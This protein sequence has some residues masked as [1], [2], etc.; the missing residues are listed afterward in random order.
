MKKQLNKLAVLLIIAA[1]FTLSTCDNIIG[2][3]ERLNLKGPVVTIDYPSPRQPV[4][5]K[6]Y[7]SGTISDITGVDRVIIRAKYFLEENG[8]SRNADFPMQWR[9]TGRLWEVSTN[10]G[11]SWFPLDA[12]T[13]NNEDQTVITPKWDGNDKA[14]NWT[15]PIN[16]S[17][18]GSDIADGLYQFTVMAWNYAGNSDENSMRS[19]NVILYKD[20]PT[21]SIISPTP[22]YSRLEYFNEDSELYTLRTMH[23]TP[24]EWR[25]PIYNSKF[26]NGKFNLQWQIED[27]NDVWAIEIRFYEIQTDLSND[28][29]SPICTCDHGSVCT[30]ENYEDDYVFRMYINDVLN[31]PTVPNPVHILRPNG[32]IEVPNLTQIS[33]GTISGASYHVKNPVSGNTPLQVVVTCINAAGLEFEERI[34]G[35]FVYWPESEKPWITFPESLP[36]VFPVNPDNLLTVFPAD[37]NDMEAGVPAKAFAYNPIA[38]VEYSIFRVNGSGVKEGAAVMFSEVPGSGTHNLVQ[39]KTTGVVTTRNPSQTKS[40]S[41]TFRPPAEITSYVVEAKAFDIHNNVSAEYKGYFKTK[42]VSWPDIKAPHTPVSTTPL[43]KTPNVIN[44]TNGENWNFTIRGLASDSVNVNSVYMVWIN[45]R[46][47]NYAAMSQ[48]AYFRDAEYEGWTAAEHH[49]RNVANPPTVPVATPGPYID[50]AF[51]NT[52]GHE[53][54]V[55]KLNIVPNPAN[56]G[57]NEQRRREVQY[58]INLKLRDDLNIWP[59]APGW[60]FLKSQVFVFKVTGGPENK[61]SVIVW[62]PEGSNIAPTVQITGVRLRKFDAQTSTHLPWHSLNLNMADELDIFNFNDQLE[63][64]G[65]WSED[66]AAYLGK[67]NALRDAFNVRIGNAVIPKNISSPGS[68]T[69]NTTFVINPSNDMVGNGTWTVTATVGN[70]NNDTTHVLRTGHL[71]DTLMINAEIVNIGGHKSEDMQT[72][73]VKSD[74]LSFM[75]LG[76]DPGVLDR[77]YKAGDHIDF[78]L[79][80]NKS[81]QLLSGANPILNLNSGTGGNTATAVYRTTPAQTA[82]STRQYFRYTVGTTDSTENIADKL[83]NVMSLNAGGMLHGNSNYPFTFIHGSETVKLVAES[84]AAPGEYDGYRVNILPTATHS[85]AFN[86][87]K[88]IEIDTRA[89]TLLSFAISGRGGWHG[90]ND[91]L[92]ITADFSEPVSFGAVTPSLTLGIANGAAT[93]RTTDR[94]EQNRNSLIFYYKVKANDQATAASGVVITSF[95]GNVIDIAGNEYNKDTFNSLA[96]SNR[97]PRDN[98]GTAARV[99]AI[100]LL[101]PTLEVHTSNE[102]ITPAGT[103]GGNFSQWD[104]DLYA[105]SNAFLNSTVPMNK[106]HNYYSE[107]LFVFIKPNEGAVF[108]PTFDRIEYSVNYGKDW[109][110]V[111]RNTMIRKN[112]PGNYELTARQVDAAG[113]V[114]PWSRPVTLF[115]DKG[116]LL[117]RIT[118]DK[119][120]GTYTD[121]S[122][123]IIPITLTFRRPVRVVTA[124]A[125]RLN[126]RSRTNGAQNYIDLPIP[127]MPTAQDT[128]TVN[129]TVGAN[130]TTN[131]EIIQVMDIVGG[132]F[133]DAAGLVVTDMVNLDLVNATQRNFQNQKNIIIQTGR[134][135]RIGVPEFIPDANLN[136]DGTVPGTLQIEFSSRI[137]RGLGEITIVQSAIGYRLPGVISEAQFNLYRGITNFTNFYRKGT[138]GYINGVGPDT[139]TK[140]ILD[141]NVNT[142]TTTHS[143]A[144]LN[145]QLTGIA[146][147]LR[148]AEGM[149]IAINSSFVSIND[150][151]LSIRLTGTNSLKVQGASYEIVYPERFIQD[152]LGNAC[153]A[154][155]GTI[156]TTGVARPTIR[157]SKPRETISL[158]GTPST[159]QPRIYL[160]DLERE[161]ISRVQIRMDC[162]T[163]G[164]TVRYTEAEQSN[165]VNNSAN[166]NANWSWVKNQTVTNPLKLSDPTRPTAPTSGSTLFNNAVDNGMITRGPGAVSGTN[167]DIYNGYK[168]RIYAVGVNGTTVGDANSMA[169]EVLF[170][171]VLTFKGSA[172]TATGGQNFLTS[173]VGNQLWVRGSNEMTGTTIAGFPLTPDDNFAQL[174]AN[175]ERAGIRLMTRINTNDV[176]LNNSTWQYVTW[177]INAT[178]FITLYLGNDIGSSAAMLQQYGPQN[179][180]SQTENW[181]LLKEF[182]VMYPGE[183]RWLNNLSPQYNDSG[184]SRVGPFTFVGAFTQRPTNLTPNLP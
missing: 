49:W 88:T 19:R 116:D 129:Y 181:S 37:P 23:E 2:L 62:S 85:N 121:D 158:H 33:S 11:N 131:G 81:V 22:L 26:Y 122:D 109:A 147:D 127:V 172:V 87:I 21:V 40:F 182:Y 138:N 154:Y 133:H 115:W 13:L 39:D 34:A 78:F 177:D 74:F 163:P 56:G 123:G 118:T 156:T 7:L 106:L 12:V 136:S 111:N 107:Q 165:N 144:L 10:F 86:K 96:D 66:S 161:R 14:A 162:R 102:S 63:I 72:W 77:T 70:A 55:W 110:T 152:S 92:I 48:L 166:N 69:M 51:D 108:E 128:I 149:R 20:P 170:R 112:I 25:D 98:R 71:R 164:S 42:D 84:T 157:S 103:S 59:G 67:T 16:L 5:D 45:P 30:C 75:Q 65:S 54:K 35:C 139:S 169:E 105:N 119:P 178:A 52:P 82:A 58:S 145:T 89:P 91:E 120:S 180:A 175:N 15:V 1:A 151:V 57:I 137:T 24:N 90:E 97:I 29:I 43:Y 73:F 99:R 168:Y 173:G 76:T 9:F 38:R 141:F 41:W 167:M 31:R 126:I 148:V 125:L 114:S 135:T 61:T 95:N 27:K 160:T 183:H 8:A 174:Q 171:T 100:P 179:I 46:S 93:T 124:S 159:T 68:P 140:Y 80:F 176:D 146:S 134:P 117:T 47:A 130:D 142:Y 44:G 150:N 101:V 79:E 94:V 28:F 6:F 53:N 153:D 50:G 113:N 83:L 64:N 60:E 3:G 143:N 36:S 32:R 184:S 104:P 17:L 155:T 4:D 132:V 18:V